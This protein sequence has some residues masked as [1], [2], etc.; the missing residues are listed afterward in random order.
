L[1]VSIPVLVG[2]TQLLVG[3]LSLAFLKPALENPDTAGSRGFQLLSV[4]I[5]LYAFGVA[6]DLFTA[7]RQLSVWTYNVQILGGVLIGVAWLVLALEVTDRVT[8]SR[9]VWG[10]L[11]G[12][13]VLSQVALWTNPVHHLVFGPATTVD[14]VNNLKLV[15]GELFWVL[16]LGTYLC[17]VVGTV[18]LAVEVVT[19]TGIRR[20]QMATLSLA[21]IPTLVGSYVNVFFESVVQYDTTTFGYVGSAL[22]FAVAL[23]NSRFLD[24]EPIARR[25]A[26]EEISDAVVAVDAQD[27]VVD[28]N[29]RART[30]F[31]VDDDYV[32][33]DL[34]EF[35]AA[36]PDETQRRLREATDDETEV[37]VD[38]DGDQ[39]SFSASVSPIGEAGRNGRVFVI[40]DISDQKAYERELEERTRKLELLNRIVRHDINND[41]EVMTGHAEYLTEELDDD[42]AVEHLEKIIRRGDHVA[43]LTGTLR[44]LMESVLGGSETTKPVALGPILDDET[45]SVRSMDDAVTVHGPSGAVDATV[46]ADEALGVVVRNLLTNA[47]RH[48][49]TDHPEIR[50]SVD[51]VGDS[52]ELRVADDGPGVPPDRRDEIF[53]RGEKG[54]E[55]PGS[56]VGLYLVDTLV[57]DYGGDVRVTDSDHGGAAFVVRLRKAQPP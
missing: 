39:R 7:A 34:A 19:S 40:R 25:V 57:E 44:A 13:T 45:D 12:Y 4:A 41:I 42:V 32:G 38:I 1:P 43:E 5:A 33:M 47:V 51:D 26:M 6:L 3:V 30:L 37:T 55:S 53:G 52:V 48:N 22:V 20:R 8:V 46:R 27:R 35:A 21:L 11:A 18:L 36:V 49:D 24:V 14:A 9:Q 50:V 16:L 17:I 15:R 28:C 56:G 54:L 2:V 23:F 29:Q 31:G 10:V